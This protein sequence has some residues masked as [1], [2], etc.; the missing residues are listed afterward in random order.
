MLRVDP[1]LDWRG[2]NEMTKSVRCKKCGDEVEP[3][4]MLE[5]IILI[6]D[7]KEV[8]ESY[9]SLQVERRGI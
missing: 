9:C 6:H 4:N 2:T 3:P 5:H 1:D 7:D 8:A